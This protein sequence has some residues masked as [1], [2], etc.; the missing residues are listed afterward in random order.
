MG[1]EL[2]RAMAMSAIYKSKTWQACWPTW[3][4]AILAKTGNLG[5]PGK[6]L[7]LGSQLRDV[8]FLTSDSTRSQSSVSSAGTAWES[9][10][11]WYLNLVFSG[12]TAVAMRAGRDVVPAPVLDA[13]TLTYGT[14]QT[15]T[16]SDLCAIV[17][18]DD[19][20]F[21][22]PGK[23]F[24][25]QLDIAVKSSFSALELAVIQCKANWNDNAQIPMLWDLVYRA[26]FANNSN[27][28]VGR[29]GFTT[30]HLKKFSYAFVT[31]PTQK[32]PIKPGS[33]PVKRVSGLSGGNY[34]GMPT[35]SNAALSLSEIFTRNF[36]SAFKVP[37]PASIAVA[38][39]AQVGL[40]A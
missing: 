2:H 39:N 19:F 8:F 3:E 11:C 13:T 26:T 21:P 37:V 30:K 33:M 14:A 1:A 7:A 20:P 35:V 12:T 40:F 6:I 16:E 29:N 4:P 18:P 25:P 27:V 22:P 34:W 24:K 36:S 9:L 28:T 15:N 38:M 5:D 31:A 10:V 23:D 32:S 17:Y